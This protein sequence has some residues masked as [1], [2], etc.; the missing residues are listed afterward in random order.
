MLNGLWHGLQLAQAICIKFLISSAPRWGGMRVAGRRFCDGRSSLMS[1]E[2]Q[3]S[4][5]DDHFS[6]TCVLQDCGPG[7]RRCPRRVCACPWYN[8]LPVPAM[9]GV[10]TEL[11]DWTLSLPARASHAR[12]HF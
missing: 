4:K 5:A 2:S 9:D 12:H 1:C 10:T 7:L 11:H 3:G 6:C 8:S